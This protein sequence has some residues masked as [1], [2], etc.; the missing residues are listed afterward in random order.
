[1]LTRKQKDLLVIIHDQTLASG[2]VCSSFAEMSQH[3]RLKSK[4]GVYRLVKVLEARGFIRR[5]PHHARAIK[6]IRLPQSSAAAQ[7]LAHPIT[8]TIA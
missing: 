8:P 3:M 4:S 6:V 7:A 2:G 5:L 1:M